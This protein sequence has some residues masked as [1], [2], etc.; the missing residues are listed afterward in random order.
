MLQWEA[1]AVVRDEVLN[2]RL[3]DVGRGEKISCGFKKTSASGK[4]LWP[5]P[6]SCLNYVNCDEKFSILL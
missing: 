5:M 3:D 2:M 1:E 4:I 6:A